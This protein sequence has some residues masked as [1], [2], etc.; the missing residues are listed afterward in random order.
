MSNK[1]SLSL[2][3]KLEAATEAKQFFDKG[4]NYIITEYK[5]QCDLNCAFVAQNHKL[6][7]INQKLW[8]EKAALQVEI[9]ILKGNNV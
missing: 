5:K 2:D 8:E 9:A 3:D 6:I 1:K 7:N 4:I